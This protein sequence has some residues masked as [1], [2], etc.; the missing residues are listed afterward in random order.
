MEDVI[1]EQFTRPDEQLNE[2]LDIT[3]AFNR[4]AGDIKGLPRAEK[5]ARLRESLDNP[6]FGVRAQIRGQEQER[7]GWVD[8]ELIEERDACISHLRQ[9]TGQTKKTPPLL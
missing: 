5:I 1:V 7:D 4:I 9:L 2:V 3:K 6:E 8:L